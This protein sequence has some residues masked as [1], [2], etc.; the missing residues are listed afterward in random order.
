[1]S[2]ILSTEP[3]PF[4]APFLAFPLA[5]SFSFSFFVI[6]ALLFFADTLL[7][8][9]LALDFVGANVVVTRFRFVATLTSESERSGSS[10]SALLPS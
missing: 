2:V 8:L 6:A 9:V 4:S 1:M 10:S 3:F 7:G 5:L